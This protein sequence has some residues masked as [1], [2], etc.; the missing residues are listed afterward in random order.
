MFRSLEGSGDEPAGAELEEREALNLQRKMAE[1][2]DDSDFG[3]GLFKVGDQT[4]NFV[5]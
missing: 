4:S 2:L 1:Q 5:S 3:L